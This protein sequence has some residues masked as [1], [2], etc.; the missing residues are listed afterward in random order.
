MGN[1]Y[2]DTR[3]SRR[4]NFSE[5]YYW[6]RDK[7][8]TNYLNE[9]K[10]DYENEELYV[11]QNV[12][13]EPQDDE[14]IAYY[15][16]DFLGETSETNKTNNEVYAEKSEIAKT[17]IKI[18]YSGK[19]DAN[20]PKEMNVS[21][22]IVGGVLMTDS[23]DL[24]LETYDDLSELEFNDIVLFEGDFY[25]VSRISSKPIRKNSVEFDL[26]YPKKYTIVLRK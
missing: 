9:V 20:Q 22:N 18:K 26:D 6:K 24:V 12:N 17:D 10:F 14:V 23:Y 4:K 21:S 15:K 16:S 25:M 11:H 1:G 7:I 13:D 19:F 8:N 2:V 5:C 3:V